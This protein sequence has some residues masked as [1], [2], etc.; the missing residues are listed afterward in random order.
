VTLTL[1]LPGDRFD[2]EHLLPTGE[3]QLTIAGLLIFKDGAGQRAS[4]EVEEPLQPR[5]EA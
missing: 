3:P 1:E 4:A 5:Y 2:Q